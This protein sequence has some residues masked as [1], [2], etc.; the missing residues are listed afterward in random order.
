M[1]SSTTRPIASTRPKSDER[2]DGKPHQRKECK[3]PD[4]RDRDG[5][6]WNQRRAPPLQENIDDD[7]DENQGFKERMDDLLDAFP[8][9]LGRIERDDVVEIGRELAFISSISLV[10]ASTV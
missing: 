9:G 4:Q 3:G 10:A 8:H 5:E 7:N 2:V 1:A 6:Q